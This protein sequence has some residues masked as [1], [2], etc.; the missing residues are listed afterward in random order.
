M[1]RQLVRVVA[2]VVALAV[3]IAVTYALL[4][5][6]IRFFDDPALAGEDGELTEVPA[7]LA[8]GV[9]MPQFTDVTELWGLDGWQTR[10]ENRLRGGVALGDLDGDGRLDMI[11]AGGSLVAYLNRGNTFERVVGPRIGDAI[12]VTLADVDDDGFVD[13][14]VGSRYSQAAI[15]WGGNWAPSGASPDPDFEITAIGSVDAF[16][17]GLLAGHLNGDA[18]MD[19]VQL[20]YDSFDVL[21][22]QSSNREFRAVE[23][24]NSDRQSM[25]AALADVDDDGLTDIWVTRDVGWVTGADSVYS[26]QGDATGRYR[27]IAR[28][29][30]AD[31][32]IDGMGVTVA[33]FDLDGQLDVYLS[34]LGDNELLVGAGD[35]FE[36]SSTH[37]MAHI[38]PTNAADDII[39]SSWTS[40]AT[41][42]NHDGLLDLVVVHGGFAS[43]MVP[44]KIEGSTIADGEPPTIFVSNGD[45]TYADVWPDLGIDWSGLSRGMALGD[46]DGDGDS[47]IVTMNHGG[48]MFVLRNDT[49]GPVANIKLNGCSSLRADVTT[50][51]ARTITTVAPG[52][53]FLSGHAPEFAVGGELIDVRT[54]GGGLG[55]ALSRVVYL[56]PAEAT[57]EC[58]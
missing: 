31:L 20:D 45:G 28:D 40:G 52:F 26:R 19:L 16:T 12:S 39:S 55:G 57:I 49:P 17:T 1:L 51:D 35:R 32:E 5:L 8:D 23:L 10:G 29:L 38:R 42:I 30:G 41:D 47:D 24:P 54:S 37:G 22:E 34:D 27:D 48:G 2:L 11:A 18:S 46:L 21:W 9:P 33:D 43:A 6:A 4:T 25:T 15:V 44:N 56:S 58:R 7:G 53:G 14:L 13:T 50:T 36:K 3:A